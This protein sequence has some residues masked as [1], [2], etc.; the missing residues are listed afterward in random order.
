MRRAPT[1]HRPPATVS[2]AAAEARLSDS[3][4]AASTASVTV[5]ADSVGTVGQPKLQGARARCR[6][7][8]P[9]QPPSSG[10]HSARAL[11]VSFAR[12]GSLSHAGEA[13][14]SGGMSPVVRAEKGQLRRVEGHGDARRSVIVRRPADRVA[15]IDCAHRRHPPA[16]TTERQ[17]GVNIRVALFAA[18]RC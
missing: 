2:V 9:A 15:H 6:S 11:P 3:S 12:A 18:A 4:A 10:R 17:R 7:M 14:P 8:W 1:A 5:S 13:S 16:C